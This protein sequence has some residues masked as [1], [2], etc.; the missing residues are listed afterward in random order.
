MSAALVLVTLSVAML[1]AA[2]AG[3]SPAA[4]TQITVLVVPL[5]ISGTADEGV[6]TQPAGTPVMVLTVIPVGI[7]SAIV[8]LAAEVAVPVFWA[9]NV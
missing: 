3:A 8:V 7:T 5:P 9:V 4:A 1:V 2:A 6:Q